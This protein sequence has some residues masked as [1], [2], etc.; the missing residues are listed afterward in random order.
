MEQHYIGFCA[1]S[2]N[3]ITLGLFSVLAGFKPSERNTGRTLTR[4][5]AA[6]CKREN[7]FLLAYT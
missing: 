3:L 4:I 6:N 7:Y 5:N 2:I 1:K